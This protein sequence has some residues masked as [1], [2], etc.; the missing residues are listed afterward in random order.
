L[1][2]QKKNKAKFSLAGRIKS[3][4]VAISK[5]EKNMSGILRLLLVI[6]FATFASAV[7]AQDFFTA[8]SPAT[9]KQIGKPYLQA[10]HYRVVK[11]NINLAQQ[12]LRAAPKLN[13]VKNAAGKLISIPMPDGS[14]HTYRIYENGTMHPALAAKFPEIRT[15][16]GYGVTNPKEFVKLDFTPLGFHAMI[17]SPGK[18]AVFIDPYQF[19]KTNYYMVYKRSDFM[20]NKTTKCNVNNTTASFN[21][22]KQHAVGI[23]YSTCFLRTYRLAVAATAEY[24]A[25]YGSQ[26]LALA[27]QITTINRV[28][29]VYE[30]DLGVTLELIANN[31]N[32]VFTIPYPPGVTPYTSGDSF[33]MINQNPPNID[34]VIGAGNYDIGHVFDRNV[35]SSGLAGLGVVCNISAKAEGVT[36]SDSPVGDPFDID[37]VAHE[38]GHEFNANHTQNNPC[39]R[40]DATA[41]EPG[42]AST[43]M[44]YAGICA[45]NVQL[46]SDAYFNGINLQEIG[47]F[48]TMGA[49]NTCGVPTVIPAAPIVSLPA[50]I[51]IPISTPFALT[52][53][54]AGAGS[55][56]F[57]FTWEQQDNGI[58]AQPP[59]PTATIGPN[60]R[61]ITPTLDS[62]RYLPG[63]ASLAS[64]GP[65]TWEVLP[66]VSRTMN[67]RVSVRG[68]TAGGSCNAYQDMTV[69]SVAAAGPFTVTYPTAAGIV[70]LRNSA[71]TVTW[72]VA[73]TTSAPISAALVDIFLSQDG[74]LSFPVTLAANVANNGSYLLTI[75]A[76][77]TNTGRVMVRASSGNFF[78]VS[79]NNF[80][81]QGYGSPVITLAVRNP[82]NTTEAYL[83]YSTLGVPQAPTFNLSGVPGAVLTL[84]APN[85][86]FIVSNIINATSY[87]NVNV[88][89][90]DG[91]D[92]YP[93]NTF[94]IPG[95]LTAP[96]LTVA[97]RNPFLGTQAFIYYSSISDTPAQGY[98]V[99]GI[100]GATVNIDTS[101]GRFVV[102][103]IPTPRQINNVTIAATD[104][105]GLYTSNAVTIPNIL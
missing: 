51:S 34:F 26:A 92:Q 18:T 5:D 47:T 75:P 65:F 57:T 94:S 61:S 58:S 41:V 63:L 68:N 14:K 84:D 24:T 56:N 21:H 31:N 79:S 60:F 100:P 89:G 2:D 72:N 99:N 48:V 103:N 9:A 53:M 30:T 33:A 86:R 11:I 70:W 71:Q 19:K 82:Q 16:N 69:T 38:M 87:N 81:I 67:F 12:S 59:A 52:G 102:S 74:G 1:P 23:D 49:G 45:P 15:Y 96:I 101:H 27:G 97:D 98:V 78:A 54:A 29:G 40:N 32:I 44:G 4:A 39:N 20:T 93:S 90:T 43:I 22:F 50:N 10:T 42:S 66:S 105:F 88:I 80:V 85:N 28:N 36:G 91:I 76:T 35:S 7:Q 46:N 95:V 64:N 62:T 8:V 83:F 77:S 17:L 37:Y 55:A 13:H 73:N 25:F 3:N 6:V 104:G